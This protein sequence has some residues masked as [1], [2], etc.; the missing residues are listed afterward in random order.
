MMNKLFLIICFVFIVVKNIS[1][2]PNQMSKFEW[3][4]RFSHICLKISFV[5]GYLEQK[6]G[7]SLFGSLWT[8]AKVFFP[9]ILRKYWNIGLVLMFMRAQINFDAMAKGKFAKC[10]GILQSS[11]EKVT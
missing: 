10:V 3:L 8:H 7:Y 9:R 2:L 5:K 11:V 4:A 6:V 1:S